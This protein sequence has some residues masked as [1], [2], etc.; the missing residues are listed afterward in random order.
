MLNLPVYLYTPAIRV[1]LD[2]ENSTKNGVDKMYHGYINIAKAIKNTI[3]FNF[4]NG[5]QRPI[6]I[7][8]MS[9]EFGLFDQKTNTR[10]V[11]KALTLLD[12][13]ITVTTSAAQTAVGKT[14][15][16]TSTTGLFTGQ[17]VTGT[18]IPAKTV[19]TAVTSTTVTLSN[20]TTAIVP[21]GATIDCVTFSKKGSAELTL[22]DTD[23]SELT[24]GR[25][26]YSILR[27]ESGVLSPVFLDGASS[28]SGSVEV[29]DSVL[30][31]FIDSDVLT[32]NLNNTGVRTTGP[33]AANR[34]G[35]GGNAIHSAALY[36]TNFS[37]TVDIYGS[38]DNSPTTTNWAQI[39]TTTY[40]NQTLTVP[41]NLEGVFNYF[42]FEYTPT[43]GSIDKVLYRS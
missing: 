21:L 38:L 14:L 41:V 9:F 11:N 19:I 22:I 26:T 24:S 25:Y 23:T 12:D 18:N 39:D 3:R 42:K 29:T 20:D 16:F 27:N 17:S 13:S 5:D 28:M 35:R 2:L 31:R 6:N 15:T 33:V 7:N 36:F 8:G 40:T 37:G 1:F 32:F 4:V 10:L 43:A 30:P 34:D